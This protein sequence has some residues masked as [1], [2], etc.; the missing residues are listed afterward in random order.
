M[1]LPARRRDRARGRCVR[2]RIVECRR[3]GHGLDV[4]DH[5]G[6]WLPERGVPDVFDGAR[7]RPSDWQRR[8]P[9]GRRRSRWWRA[10]R[11]AAIG[12]RRVPVE[13]AERRRKRPRRWCEFGGF[14]GV[15]VVPE[16]PRR[17]GADHNV[18]LELDG[19]RLIALGA[20]RG[21]ERSE[22]RGREPNMPSAAA[23]AR[24]NHHNHQWHGLTVLTEAVS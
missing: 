19:F 8:G 21:A 2:R 3:V 10:H 14:A 13:A 6:T 18:G 15:S 12:V 22:V 23:D 9:P 5:S 20:Q 1:V 24:R 17:D 11:Q 7:R 16:R 4:D